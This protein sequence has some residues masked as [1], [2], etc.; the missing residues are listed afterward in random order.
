LTFGVA[1][2]ADR[3]NSGGAWW[4]FRAAKKWEAHGKD[5]LT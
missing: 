3:H 1:D 4:S 5:C 2:Q